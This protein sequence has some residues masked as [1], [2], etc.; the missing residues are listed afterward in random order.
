MPWFPA[1][2]QCLLGPLRGKARQRGSGVLKPHLQLG[3]ESQGKEQMPASAEVGLV[4]REEAFL[5]PTYSG[6]SNIC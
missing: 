3:Q 6:N 5:L 2:V 1:N 4:R